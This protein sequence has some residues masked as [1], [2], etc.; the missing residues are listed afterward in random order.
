MKNPAIMRLWIKLTQ[1]A[2][3]CAQM[4]NPQIITALWRIISQLFPAFSSVFL[5]PFP[6][7]CTYIL[8][9]FPSYLPKN[10]V[11]PEHLMLNHH[12]VIKQIEQN[13]FTCIYPS[14]FPIVLLM[15]CPEHD[16]SMGE[17]SFLQKG[18]RQN[19]YSF[20]LVINDYG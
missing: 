18:T 14:H 5:V 13:T 1:L 19:K 4:V 10:C 3:T 12:V 9:S 8:H 11:C 2:F 16:I 7:I 6:C 20:H 17:L 15:L